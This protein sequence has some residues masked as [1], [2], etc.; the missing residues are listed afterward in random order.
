MITASFDASITLNDHHLAMA[1]RSTPKA[2]AVAAVRMA[3]EQMD[4]SGWIDV[5]AQPYP[6]EMAGW[7][8]LYRPGRS[9][10]PDTA[11]WR[12]LSQRVEENAVAALRAVEGPS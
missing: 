7:V 6:P 8:I 9:D 3:I 12:A 5:E 11:A 1:G 2:D 10:R 4:G